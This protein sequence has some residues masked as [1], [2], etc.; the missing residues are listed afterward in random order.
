MTGKTSEDLVQAEAE[1][2][3]AG[4]A[5][6]E[7]GLALLLAEM[8]ALKGVMSGSVPLAE[9]KTDAETEADFDNMPV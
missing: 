2:L 9:P 7:Q 4:I 3:S 5:L 8:Q 1:L 6:Q